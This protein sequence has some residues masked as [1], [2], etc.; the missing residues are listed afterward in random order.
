MLALQTALA[1]EGEQKHAHLGGTGSEKKTQDNAKSES[2][3]SDF[4]P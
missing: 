2:L 4:C 1:K 3:N